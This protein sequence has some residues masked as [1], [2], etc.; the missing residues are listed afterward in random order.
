MKKIL[1]LLL[2]IS[3]VANS[4][5]TQ[6]KITNDGYS[7]YLV[8][9]IADKSQAEIYKK[10]LGWAMVNYKNPERVI[11]VKQ[12][13]EYIRINALFGSNSYIVE[14]AVK[15]GKYKFS[16]I[17]FDA[18]SMGITVSLMDVKNML[19]KQGEVKWIY[20]GHKSN[21]DYLNELN[22]SLKDFILNNVEVSKQDW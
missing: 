12:E 13:N 18:I 21:I 22:K 15:D 5:G 11:T 3:G 1:I 6:F 19:N 20:G 16:L 9:E 10:V 14:I 2:L 17:A 4:Q 7:R 8:E